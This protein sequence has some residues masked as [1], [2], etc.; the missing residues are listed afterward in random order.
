MNTA[1]KK[2]MA[3]DLRSGKLSNC[4][5]AP[6]ISQSINGH[7]KCSECK[8]GAVP[9]ENETAENRIIELSTKKGRLREGM[10]VEYRQDKK[11]QVYSI[12]DTKTVL[13]F[14]PSVDGSCIS[15]PIKDIYF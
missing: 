15:V 13:I 5:Q 1:E 7:G 12:L 14:Y 11:V 4:C 3:I 6:I 2:A 8:D 10:F 9:I